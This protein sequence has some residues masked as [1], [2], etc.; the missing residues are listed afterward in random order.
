MSLVQIIVDCR[1]LKR[2]AQDVEITKSQLGEKAS[3]LGAA[4]IPVKV[5]FGR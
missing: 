5:L 2:P 3:V 4:I 1:A